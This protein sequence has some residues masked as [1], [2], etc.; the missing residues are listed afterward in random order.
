MTEAEMLAET[1]A[2]N[3]SLEALLQTQPP[4]H[5]LPPAVT[6]RARREGR[7]I[8]G[9]LVFSGRA[10][11]VTIPGRGGEISL[12]ILEPD[13][14]RGAYLH[15]HGGG[16][17]IG[18]A[19]GQD[20]LLWDL[21]EATGLTTVSVE[22]RLAPEHPFPAGPDDCEDA[23]LWLLAHHDGRLTI[24]GESA[25]AQLAVLTLL[26]L[27]DL[28]GVSP[29]T[30]AAANLVFGAYDL[31]G[32]PSRRLWGTRELV[33]SS[34]MMD[35]FADCFLPGLTHEERRAPAIS[36]LYAELHDLPP[37]L[38]SCGTADPLLDDSL[39]MEAR[40][41]QAGNET[42]LSLWEEDIHAFTAFPLEIA[43]RSRAEQAAF[44]KGST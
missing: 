5:T 8:F 20:P 10:R 41:R 13:S 39:F 19:D 22:Y 24:G 23:A 9:P 6:R 16:W 17:T 27:R 44:L 26:R 32:T 15:V 14:P 11:T 2:F 42:T 12:R 28:H 1:I 29:R 3:T 25:G 33:L 35:W 36:P 43:R 31:T 40:W 37:A 34:P 7:G 21:A 18:S 38:F 4:V 30:F